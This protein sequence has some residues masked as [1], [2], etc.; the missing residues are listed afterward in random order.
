MKKINCQF[1]GKEIEGYKRDHILYLL[2][3]HILSKHPEQVHFKKANNL[4]KENNTANSLFSSTINNNNF[5]D[6]S[7]SNNKEKSNG[8]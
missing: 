5:S 6:G 7:V 4:S 8:N 2:R 3:Q 1:C